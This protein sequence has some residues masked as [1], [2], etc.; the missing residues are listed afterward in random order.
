MAEIV[1]DSDNMSKQVPDG[2]KIATTADEAQATLPFGCREASCGAC[3]LLVLEGME[4]LSDVIDDEV[5][6]LGQDKINEG[7][8]LGCQISIKSGKVVIRNG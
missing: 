5:E 4:N 2:S 8:R 7:Y 3:R 1:F 6:V